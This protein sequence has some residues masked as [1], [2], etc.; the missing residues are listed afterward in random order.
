MKILNELKQEGVSS[1]MAA[2]LIGSIL[3]SLKFEKEVELILDNCPPTFDFSEAGN[4]TIEKIDRS[5][6]VMEKINKV[7]KD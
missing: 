3:N 7:E 1:L 2:L 6:L 4:I 5:I